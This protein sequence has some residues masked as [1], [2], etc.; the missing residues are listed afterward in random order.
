MQPIV[1]AAPVLTDYLD[2]ESRAH[3]ETVK[4]LLADVGVS[5]TINPRLVRGL[6]YY[7]RTVFEWIT[8]A[9]GA[10]SAVCSGGRYDGLVEQLGGRPT[11]AV[12]W[13]LGVERV[14]ELM[15]QAGT[16]VESAA[17]DVC[18]VS[19]GEAARRRSFALAETLRRAAPALSIVLA[20]PAASLKAQL[21]R[22]DRLGA[23]YAVIIG[24]DELAAGDITLKPLLDRGDQERIGDSALIERL[25][26]SVR[27]VQ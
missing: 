26:N 23:R 27:P 20:Q 7:S 18:F 24:E 10:Q 4:D 11:P 8:G 6:D 25:K 19:V 22:A 9:L 5:C 2:D 3:F 1:A 13:A 21:K 17:A 14:V 12:G 15:Q 16:D